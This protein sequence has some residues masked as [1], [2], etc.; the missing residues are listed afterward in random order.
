M[1]HRYSLAFLT[2]FELGH[3]AAVRAAAAAPSLMPYRHRSAGRWSAVPKY[4][5]AATGWAF[6]RWGAG[7]ASA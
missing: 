7:W 6:H 2:V 3:A 5:C 4:R 1:T